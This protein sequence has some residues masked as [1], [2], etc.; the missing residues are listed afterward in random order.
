MIRVA[1]TRGLLEVKM[2]FQTQKFPRSPVTEAMAQA[3]L[4]TGQVD[5]SIC[6]GGRENSGEGIEN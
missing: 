6:Q 3:G 4:R 5:A 2:T 1:I